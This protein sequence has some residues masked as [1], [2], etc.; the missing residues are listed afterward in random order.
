[1]GLFDE[2]FIPCPQCGEVFCEQSKGAPC[3]YLD[4]YEIG[5]KDEN[6]VIFLSMKG[7]NIT[8]RDGYMA[9][10]DLL[11]EIYTCD[12]CGY[13]FQFQAEFRVVPVKEETL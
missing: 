3:P 10:G 8:E 2:I 4:K 6:R 11:D 1:M 12:K 5:Y 13:R 9:L 7:W